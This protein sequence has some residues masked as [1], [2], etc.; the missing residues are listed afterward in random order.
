[1]GSEMASW[2]TALISVVHEHPS[3]TDQSKIPSLIQISTTWTK[4]I[5]RFL[6]HDEETTHC[7]ETGA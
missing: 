1:M 4:I 6:F 2:L 3:T 7:P 5:A